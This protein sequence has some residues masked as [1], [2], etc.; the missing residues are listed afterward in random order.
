MNRPVTRTIRVWAAD[1]GDGGHLVDVP[2]APTPVPGL[3]VNED[4]NVHGRWNITHLPSGCA[5]A[6][7]MDSPEQALGLAIKLGPVTD[8]S[9]PAKVLL[10]SMPVIRA[11]WRYVMDT[12]GALDYSGGPA[13]SESIV[14]AM[15]PLS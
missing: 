1:P 8:W 11:R 14:A 2:A 6:A 12:A 15:E 13:A 10:D 3:Y 5:V 4:P 7:G 9:V